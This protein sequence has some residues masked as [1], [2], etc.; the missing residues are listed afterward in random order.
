[1]NRVETTITELI[2]PLID[3]AD[4]LLWDVSFAKE[5][6]SKVLR[7]LVDKPNHEFVTMQNLTAFTNEVNE[8][9]DTVDPDPIPEAYMLDISSPGADRPLNE[10][11]QYQWAVEA[12]EPILVSLFA[13]KEGAKKHL[14]RI[15]D[16]TETGLTLVNDE[17]TLPLTFTEI[18]KANL[19][20]EI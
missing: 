5:G 7:I 4:L 3:A 15:Q 12:D 20:V 19:A 18:A 6:G 14:G 11:W 13:P 9:L 2:T 16:L 17:V 10:L 1:M 8:L